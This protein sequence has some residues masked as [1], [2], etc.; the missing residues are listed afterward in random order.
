VFAVAPTYL[1]RRRGRGNPGGG[2]SK[3][4]LKHLAKHASFNKLLPL[5]VETI[6]LRASKV[7]VYSSTKHHKL[8]IWPTYGVFDNFFV[9]VCSSTLSKKSMRIGMMM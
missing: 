1:T 2:I 8:A 6:T 7:M 3:L 5:L 9:V 4:Y